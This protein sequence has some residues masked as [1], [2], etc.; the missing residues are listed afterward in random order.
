M[1]DYLADVKKYATN[2]DEAAVAVIV[3]YCGIALSKKDSAL[4]SGSD[5]KELATVRNGFASKKLGLS[6]DAADAG[7]AAVLVKLKGVTHKSRVTFYYLL[8]EATGTLVKL[9]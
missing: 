6:P 9:G 4:V 7:I 8:A 5:P 3:R 2:V 1:S